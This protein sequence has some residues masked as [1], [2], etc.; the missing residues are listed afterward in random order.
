MVYNKYNYSFL[1]GRQYN[2][3]LYGGEFYEENRNQKDYSSNYIWADCCYGSSWNATQAL[4]VKNT[5][6]R[7]NNFTFGNIKIDMTEPEWEKLTPDKKVVYPE[8]GCKKGPAGSE[9]R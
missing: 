9:Y 4:L 7:A 1:F 5:E 2:T 8:Q 6:Q 3:A